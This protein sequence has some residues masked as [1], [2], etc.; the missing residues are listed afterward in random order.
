MRTLALALLILFLAPAQAGAYSTPDQRPAPA[1]VN[2]EIA[3]AVSFWQARGVTGCPNGIVAHV[4]NDL[5]GANVAGRG[6]YCE[7]WIRR[8]IV[9]AANVSG[10]GIVCVGGYPAYD[11]ERDGIEAKRLEGLIVVHETGHALGLD[12]GGVDGYGHT[13]TGIMSHDAGNRIPMEIMRLFPR[14]KPKNCA[15][16]A[17]RAR[18][19]RRAA[20]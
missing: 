7:M 6:I 14:T 19:R 16:Q 8:D 13:A 15:K 9:A 1:R 20:A 5:D 12:H 2:Q 3:A 11:S 4:S 10:N 17:R 18:A